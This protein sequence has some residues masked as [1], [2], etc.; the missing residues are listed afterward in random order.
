MGLLSKGVAT[1]VPDENQNTGDIRR[2]FRSS[3][4]RAAVKSRFHDNRR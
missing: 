3:G 2:P 1:S 4:M